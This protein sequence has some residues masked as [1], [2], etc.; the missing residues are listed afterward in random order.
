[1]TNLEFYKDELKR[2]IKNNPK[3][4]SFK[5]DMI[6]EAF[7]LFSEER[8]D[9]WCNDEWAESQHFIDWLLEEHR[10]PIK[11][12][13][14]EYDLIKSYTDIDEAWN[15]RILHECYVI[16]KMCNEGYFKNVDLN[17]TF[18]EVLDNCEAIDD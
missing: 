4:V 16:R 7:T 3:E 11:L 2:Y 18:R 1:M 17:M 10:E 12:T 5:S 6:G 14:W 9:I 13:R 15:G 8:I